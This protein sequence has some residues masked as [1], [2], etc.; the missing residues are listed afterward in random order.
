MQLGEPWDYS[1]THRPQEEQQDQRSGL[2][3]IECE[4]PMHSQAEMS[5]TSVCS[6]VKW[7][8]I[9]CVYLSPRAVVEN[10]QDKTCKRALKRT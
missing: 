4:L 10:K 5:L 9:P 2:E 3:L 8:N 6:S 1:V 7:D